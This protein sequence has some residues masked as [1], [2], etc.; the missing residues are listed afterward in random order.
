MK[1]MVCTAYGAPDVLKLQEVEK[2]IPKDRE[3]RIKIY[4]T[5]VN[6]GDCRVRGFR[7][8][9]LYRIPM[10]LV[11]GLRKPR[12]PILGV[13]LAGEVEAIGKDVTRFKVGDQV[14][15]FRGM[16]FGT[17]AQYICMREDALLLLK[18]DH[19]TY[20][21]AAAVSFGGT[22]ALHFLRKG[23]IRQGHKVLIY[24]A[25]GAV[26]TLAVQLA[27]Q[28]Y[29]AEVTGVCSTAN[30]GLVRS[31]GAD[32]VI[33]YTKEDF[34]T[35]GARYDIILDAVGKLPKSRCKHLLTQGE[36]YVT[37]EGQG[38]AKVLMEDLR[39][40]VELL[41]KGKIRPVIDR[42]YVLEQMAEAHRYVDEGRKRGS[43]VITVG[44]DH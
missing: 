8:P 38:V 11:L 5:T 9:L 13:E 27:K 10:R 35:S 6:S 41:G 40:L 44:H 31:L 20:D 24:G 43:V 2:P 16:R 34:T 22:T 14:L 39:L 25:S 23:N 21:D 18:P 30:V 37:V 7:S 1:A 26:G 42:R 36:S 3:I 17:Y 32:R 19:V 29:G 4:A 15:A 28:H 33:D 12:Q